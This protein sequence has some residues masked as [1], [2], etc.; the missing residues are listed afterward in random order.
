VNVEIIRKDLGINAIVG[1]NPKIFKLAE[2]FKFTEGPIW[3]RDHLLFSDP[4]GNIIYKYIPNGDNAGKLEVFRTPSGYSGAD[5]AQDGQP[6][7]N[8]L[9]LA[10]QGRLII[11]QRGNHRVVRLEKD[12]SETLPAKKF[13]GKRLNSPTVL[14]YRSDGSL[15][16]TAPPFGLP[17][18]FDD[19]RKE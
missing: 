9:R 15:Y 1:A 6:V 5:I 11:N 2:G 14:V 18:F 10:P 8:A 7:T 16:F 13:E 4:N 12:G 3:V 19:P 17:K